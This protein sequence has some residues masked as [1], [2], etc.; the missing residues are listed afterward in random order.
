M[1]FKMLYIDGAWTPGA[2]GAYIDVENPANKKIFACVP[3]GNDAD[4]DRAAKAA[5]AAFPVWAATSL[6]ERTE[7]MKKML[8]HF[9]EMEPQLINCIIKE[10]GA[11]VSFAAASH[12]RY[13]YVR[14]QSYIDLAAGLPLVEKLPQ[15]TV[16]RAVELSLGADYPEGRPG[17][18]RRQYSRAE[19]EPAYALSCLLSDRGLPQGRISAGCVQSRNRPGQSNRQRHVRPSFD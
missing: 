13:Q 18:S 11:P 2:S 7:Y 17:D 6:S 10:L 3:A 4:V 8:T 16:Y 14:T 12:V 5:A 1:N 9:K 19:A 15:S